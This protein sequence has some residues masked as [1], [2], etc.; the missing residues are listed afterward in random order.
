MVTPAALGLW[1]PS[2][3]GNKKI[4]S[5]NSSILQDMAFHIE[6]YFPMFWGGI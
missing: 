4:K 5:E 2:L 3:V 6:L 1:A